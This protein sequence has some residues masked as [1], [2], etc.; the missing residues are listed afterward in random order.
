MPTLAAAQLILA[1][2]LAALC[3]LHI[4]LTVLN[5]R[6][7]RRLFEPGWIRI[8]PVIAL[9]MEFIGFLIIRRIVDIEV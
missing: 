9:I 3:A 6:Q 1:V 7:V 5:S 4:Y 8:V 2:V